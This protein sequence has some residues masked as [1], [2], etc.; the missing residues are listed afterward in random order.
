MDTYIIPYLSVLANSD[1][2]SKWNFSMPYAESIHM[3][4]RVLAVYAPYRMIDV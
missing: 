2:K 3:I 4:S 1:I